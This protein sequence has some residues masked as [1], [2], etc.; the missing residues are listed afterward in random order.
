MLDLQYV[1]QNLDEVKSKLARKNA[2]VEWDAILTHDQRRRAVQREHDEKR[3][4][5]GELS[6]QIPILKKKGEDA[7]A[8]LADLKVLSDDVTALATE[9]TD[10]ETALR[11]VL[12][13]VPNIPL[14]DVPFGKD[15]TENRVEKMWGTIPAFDFSPKS[16]WELGEALGIL[17]FE[18][19]A[20]ITGARFC[21]YKGLGAR[22]ERALIQLM[23]DVHTT[24]HGYTEVLPP[25]IVNR[26]SLFGTGNLP[27]FE[28]ELFGVSQGVA[29][30]S[31]E[32]PYEWFLIPTAEVP[33]TNIHRDE[34]LAADQL[35]I[36]YAAYTPCF[37]SE[38]GSYGKDVR[39]L[40][41]QHQFNKVELVQFV[42]PENSTAALESLTRDAERILELLELPYRRMTL[43]SGD[44]SFSSAK[45]H[46]LEV[47]LPGQNTYREISSCSNF[48]DFQARRA[49]I[50]Y[51][52]A[53]KKK[54][55]VHTLNGSGLAVGRTLVAILENYQQAD[56]S[57]RVPAALR[58]YLGGLERIALT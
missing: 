54:A 40:I 32:T 57:I 12:A 15:E 1:L 30:A 41:R 28:S 33:V 49:G 4:R 47:W 9:L 45:T 18:R 23:L 36:K 2:V 22:L 14:D 52:T 44:M 21:L 58:P 20:K 56:G 37:R 13:Q 26:A 46:D 6:K 34:I 42:A 8:L 38:A 25:F 7:T 11:T 3:H 31:A 17:D 48:T 43:C 53:E 35:P 24:E 10:V 55:F 51:T 5:Q 50:R 16:H 39:G 27:K 29:Y 19:A